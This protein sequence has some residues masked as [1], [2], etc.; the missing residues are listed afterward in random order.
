MLLRIVA[1][2]AVFGLTGSL[3]AGDKPVDLASVVKR[4][5]EDLKLAAAKL[6][7]P[8][9]DRAKTWGKASALAAE[10]DVRL[11]QA[12]AETARLQAR[13]AALQA[14][15]DVSAETLQA[16]DA[17]VH[18]AVAH[19]KRLSEARTQLRERLTLLERDFVRGLVDLAP[20][21]HAHDDAELLSRVHEVLAPKPAP[22]PPCRP[23]R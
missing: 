22:R 8:S 18:S 20:P 9:L 21:Q 6:A 12:R 13:L 15:G 4:L 7:P 2:F 10:L 23:S 1:L 16:A 19:E 3:T 14:L 17:A 11:T 5:E